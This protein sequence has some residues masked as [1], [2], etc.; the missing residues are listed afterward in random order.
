MN[1]KGLSIARWLAVILGISSLLPFVVMGIVAYSKLEPFR[2]LEV[3][4]H[5]M[6]W[7]LYLHT[8]FWNLNYWDSIST[9]IGEVN[10]PKKTLPKAL[11]YTL[12]LVVLS[13]FFPILIGTSS[14]PINDE[15]WTKGYFSEIAK[16]LRG[17]SLRWWIHAASAMS[18]MGMFLAEMSNDSFLLLCM[19]ERGM[20][21]EFFGKRSRHGTPMIGI[22]ISTSSVLLLSLFS[23]QEIVAAKNILYYFGT[24]LEFI[25]FVWLRVKHPSTSW[26]YKIPMG[27]VGAIPICIPPTIL[28]YVVFAFSTSK[29]LFLS[30]YNIMVGLVM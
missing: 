24:V 6:D 21:L 28:I 11:I 16:I 25:S 5:E 19:A 23:F 9:I 4:L 2:W 1:Y 22:L 3:N 14:V 18:N 17:N 7:N 10:N 13:Y 8:L 15:L 27:I 20:L 30:L 29:L 12:I 26:P